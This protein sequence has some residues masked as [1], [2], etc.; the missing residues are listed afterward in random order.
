MTAATQPLETRDLAMEL[1]RLLRKIDPAHWTPTVATEIRVR[2]Q[3][4]REPLERLIDAME[5]NGSFG[6]L[7]VALSR[8]LAV[9]TDMLPDDGLPLRDAKRA[10]KIFRT[11]L[12]HAYEALGK[13]LQA[14]DVHVP[15]LR[16]TNYKRNVFHVGWAAL[17]TATLWV[18]PQRDVL[19]PIIVFFLGSG[20]TM[21]VTRRAWPRVND[22]IMSVLGPFAHPHEWHRVNSATWYALSLFL[23]TWF[24][25]FTASLIALVVLGVGDPA[26]AIIGR[27]YGR[28]K[29]VNGR[30]LEGSLAFV[31]VG[32]T[33][34]FVVLSLAR[35]EIG[36][37]ASVAA[38]LA[39]AVAGALAELFS[40]RV[41]DNFSIP[42][43]AAAAASAVWWL[44][45]VAV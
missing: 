38:S 1:H 28:T 17:A 37:V 4:L 33:T 25:V 16:P 9:L 40:R 18:Y 42:L 11:E 26:A 23:L 30:S 32:G 35:P 39:G 27:R 6:S 43:S 19:L 21:E 5:P 31:A 44:M 36:L 10:W 7:H 20:L 34:A 41:D 13:T 22:A 24:N 8:A 15:S 3:S 45:G 2:L 29:L 14:W 12:T